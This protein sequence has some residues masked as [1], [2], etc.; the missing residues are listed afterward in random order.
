MCGFLQAKE[1]KTKHPPAIFLFLFFL[2][3]KAG[4]HLVVESNM[5]EKEGF[6]SYLLTHSSP[7]SSVQINYPRSQISCIYEIACI[8][9]CRRNLKRKFHHFRRLERK[10]RAFAH[11]ISPVRAAF[12][13]LFTRGGENKTHLAKLRVSSSSST[14]QRS[15]RERLI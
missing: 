6:F 9:K 2:W 3:A 11:H 13:C 8:G 4:A 10:F 14:Q 5:R 1:R 15:F 7:S 12:V